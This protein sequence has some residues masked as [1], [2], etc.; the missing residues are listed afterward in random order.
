MYLAK[1]Q[2]FELNLVNFVE[3]QQ[4]WSIVSCLPVPTVQKFKICQECDVE[5]L[6]YLHFQGLKIHHYVL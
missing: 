4:K 2:D 6:F 1:N 3:F 5:S